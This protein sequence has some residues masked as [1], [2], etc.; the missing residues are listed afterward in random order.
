MKSNSNVMN[1]SK[2]LSAKYKLNLF[3][4]GMYLGYFR[5]INGY[6]KIEAGEG[7]IRFEKFL[8]DNTTK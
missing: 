5:G 8:K 4:L 2:V 7:L 3:E 6:S 1:H